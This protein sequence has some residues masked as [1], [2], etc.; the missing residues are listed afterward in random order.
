MAAMRRL[1]LAFLVCVVSAPPALAAV[2]PN[3]VYLQKT[4]K[5][6][7][8]AAFKKQAPGLKI[9]TVTCKLPTNGTKS[10]CKAHFTAGSVKGYYPVT[11]TLHD[12]GGKLTW[13]A[14]KPKCFNAK[15]GKSISC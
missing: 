9:L 12:L 3:V 13:T 14:S 11:A 15:T 2:N 6:S 4:L 5:A 8:V 10:H 7:M 1:L